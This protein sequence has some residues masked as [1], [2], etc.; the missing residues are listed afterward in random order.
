VEQGGRAH[1]HAT[2]RSNRTGGLST[3]PAGCA[4]VIISVST[5]NDLLTSAID[6]SPFRCRRPEVL[7][8]CRSFPKS[9]PIKTNRSD[10]SAGL[11]KEQGSFGAPGSSRKGILEG[12][13]LLTHTETEQ[14]RQQEA[15]RRREAE[16]RRRE[17]ER[18][19]QEAEARAAGLERQLAELRARVGES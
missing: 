12:E 15:V 17:A 3:D 7:P 5:T 9:R 1:V 18:R 6:G 19:R 2:E 11:K 10:S 16:R 8:S 14:E 13:R 4:G